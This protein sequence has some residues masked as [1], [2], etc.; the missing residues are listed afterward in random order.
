MKVVGKN[1]FIVIV[2]LVDAGQTGDSESGESKHAGVSHVIDVG[3]DPA[4]VGEFGEVA[5][6]LVVA[7]HE[8]RQYGRA[9]FARIV[10]VKRLQL[11]VLLRHR[12]VSQVAVIANRLPISLRIRIIPFEYYD[13]KEAANYSI[14]FRVEKNQP[15]TGENA[16]YLKIA[17]TDE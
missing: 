12:H 1:T 11:V 10:F 3:G 17:A 9:L 2:K 7:A 15:S 4:A 5:G 16:I 13:K 8:Q 14:A 6:A